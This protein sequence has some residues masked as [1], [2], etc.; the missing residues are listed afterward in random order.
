MKQLTIFT[1]TYNRAYT[2]P[3]LYKSLLK[4]DTCLFKWLIVDDGSTDKTEEL[5]RGWIN[6]N[7]LEI[8]YI[9]QKNAGKMSAHNHGVREC[10]TELFLCCDSDDWLVEDSIKPALDFW[11]NRHKLLSGMVGPKRLLCQKELSGMVGPRDN[12]KVDYD[13]LSTLPKDEKT[14][15]LSGLYQKGYKGE[16]ALMFRTEIIRKY[17]FPIIEGEKFIPEDYVYRQLDD[18]YDLL[19]Y[20]HYCMDCEYQEDG[21]TN[22]GLKLRLKNPKGYLLTDIDSLRRSFRVKDAIRVLAL[23]D[24]I[25]KSYHFKELPHPLLMFVLF[26]LGRFLAIRYKKFAEQNNIKK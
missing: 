20:P 16:T 6:E 18:E 5:V 26:P 9:Y 13:A 4:Q 25:G 23:Y 19:I 12:N 2:L 21:Y 14:D 3:R 8:R 15:T 1:P 7:K 10:D 17:P 11:N 24:F 22:N